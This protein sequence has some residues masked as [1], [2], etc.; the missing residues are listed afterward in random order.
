MRVY[1]ARVEKDQDGRW[2]AWIDELP[3][4]AVWG[5]SREEALAALNEAAAAYIEDLAETGEI[6]ASDDG[7][8][9]ITEPIF[10]T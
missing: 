8:M 1:Q 10:T 7:D 3:G 5:Y 6:P 2:S 4:C 9:I